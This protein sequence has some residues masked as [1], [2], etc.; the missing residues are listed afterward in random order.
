MLDYFFLLLIGTFAGLAGSIVGLGGGFII[1]PFL[2]FFFPLH[3]QLIVGTSMAVLLINSLSSTYAYL[4]QKRIDVNSGIAF[5]VAMIP[6]SI[7][8]A[9]LSKF[10]LTGE[11]FH[12]AF[13]MFLLCVSLLIL[14][15]PSNPIN[16]PLRPTVSRDFQD[17]SGKTFSYSYHQGLGLTISFATGF[18]SSFLG[19]GGGS[20]MV[21]TMTILLHF[22]P[23]IAAA[24]SMLTIFVSSI[25]GTIAHG[26]M[27]HIDWSYVLF[28]APGAFIGGQLGARIASN[29]PSRA[30]MYVLGTSLIL[31]AFRLLV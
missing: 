30:L 31:V 20:I 4:R 26:L 2:L 7:I 13:G 23:H 14:L 24:T 15:K 17:Q 19:V 18:L 22:P 21:P 8:G 12:V 1:I 11:V 5:A 9:I 6:G 16:L 3:P 27:G 10:I 28:L 29:L 25:S